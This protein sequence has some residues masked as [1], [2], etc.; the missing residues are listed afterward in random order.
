[1][2]LPLLLVLLT[3]AVYRVTRLVVEDTFP[4]VAWVRDRLTGHEWSIGEPYVVE[5]WRRVP[6]WVGDLVSCCW[7]SSVWVSAG[8]TLLTWL[9]V[10]LPVPWLVWPAVA[11][12]AALLSH[13]EEYFVR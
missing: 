7:C 5:R 11:A 9:V 12:G 2:S 4:P 10:G 1:M 13:L 3:L 6:D 8:G